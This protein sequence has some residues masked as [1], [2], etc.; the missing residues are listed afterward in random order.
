MNGIM[1]TVTHIMPIIRIHDHMVFSVLHNFSH[2][3]MRLLLFMLILLQNEVILSSSIIFYFRLIN[4]QT[5]HC[6]PPKDWHH[7]LGS[8][9]QLKPIKSDQYLLLLNLLYCQIIVDQKCSRNPKK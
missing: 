5:N 1:F 7:L 4:I 9:N 2:A 6:Q 3:F 8:K